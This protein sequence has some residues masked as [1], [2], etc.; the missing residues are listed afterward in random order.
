MIPVLSALAPR[1]LT[2]IKLPVPDNIKL[3]TRPSVE[4][5]PVD[6]Y[7]AP[8]PVAVSAV[9]VAANLMPVLVVVPILFASL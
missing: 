8:T 2:P 5:L 3:D 6:T 9:T 7:S 4:T 1:D